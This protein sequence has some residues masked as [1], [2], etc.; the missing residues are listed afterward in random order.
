MKKRVFSVLL[1]MVLLFSIT[2]CGSNNSNSSQKNISNKFEVKDVSFTFDKDAEFHDYKYK[3]AD[4]IVPEESQKAVY[5]TYRNNEIYDGLYVFR[6]VLSYSENT[7]L[8]DLESIPAES[9]TQKV[10]INGVSWNKYVNEKSKNMKV[11]AYFMERN[12]T[13]YVVNIGKY[14]D[15]DVDVDKLADVFM[16]GVTIK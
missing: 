9:E 16:N 6:I 1:V 3:T 2:G 11:I 5:L 15:A 12:N 8:K 14:N 7:S 13:V 10:S 4:G